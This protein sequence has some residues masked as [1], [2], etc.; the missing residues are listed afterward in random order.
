MVRLCAKSEHKLPAVEI[1]FDNEI[2]EKFFLVSSPE[3]FFKMI[4]R[5]KLNVK[6]TKI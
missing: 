6:N 5:M 3:I 4:E 1:N 2:L